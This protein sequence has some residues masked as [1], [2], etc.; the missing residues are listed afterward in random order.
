MPRVSTLP[1]EHWREDLR[2]VAAADSATLVEQ[3]IVRVLANSPDFAKAVLTFGGGLYGSTVLSRRLIELVRIRVAFHNQCRSCMAIRYQSALDDGLTEGAVCSLE[4]PEEADDLSA[5]E[6]A[7][8]VYAD[9]SSTNHFAIDD[10]TFAAL[11]VH[12]NEQEIVE[13]GTFIAFFIGF[14]RLAASWH[15]VDDLPE[16]YRRDDGLTIKP[17]REAAIGVRG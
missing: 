14:G 8:L 3:G 9:I 10:G 7:A 2:D 11:R 17:W 15:L 13:L 1:A 12:F 16:A 4:R 5:A 6:K